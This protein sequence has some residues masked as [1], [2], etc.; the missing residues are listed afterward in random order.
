M[1]FIRYLVVSLVLVRF[2]MLQYVLK[3]TLTLLQLH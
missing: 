1:L 2:I 3:T